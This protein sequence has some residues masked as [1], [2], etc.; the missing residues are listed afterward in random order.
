M[1]KDKNVDPNSNFPSDVTA[2]SMPNGVSSVVTWRVPADGYI[3]A[4]YCGAN[5]N[6]GSTCDLYKNTASVL[7]GTMTPTA[8]AA[9]SGSMVAGTLTTN[10]TAV[11]A[12]DLIKGIVTFGTV[13]TGCSIIFT[14]RPKLGKE[15]FGY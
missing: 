8:I 9:G 2:L 14:F 13:L 11:S 6:T 5:T 7:T 15:V 10:P 4:V 1:I 12:G 3:T